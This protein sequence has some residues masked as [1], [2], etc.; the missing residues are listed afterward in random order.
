MIIRHLYKQLRPIEELLGSSG[1]L[2]ENVVLLGMLV[3]MKP[4]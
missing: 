1:R 4:V 3:Q 2:I